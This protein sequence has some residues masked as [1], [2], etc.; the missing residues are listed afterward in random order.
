[1]LVLGYWC[2]FLELVNLVYDGCLIVSDVL[3]VVDFGLLIC[4]SFPW[5]V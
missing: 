3:L 1:M 5:R 4:V 2:G